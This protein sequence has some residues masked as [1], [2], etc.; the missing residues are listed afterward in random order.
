MANGFKSA[1][2]IGSY[3]GGGYRTACTCNDDTQ[4]WCYDKKHPNVSVEGSCCESQCR[5]SGSANTNFTNRKRN[6]LNSALGRMWK[7]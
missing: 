1:K 4:T 7:K 3:E 6:K 2:V 5:D